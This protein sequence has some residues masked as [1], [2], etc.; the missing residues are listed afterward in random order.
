[1]SGLG[2]T[3]DGLFGNALAEIAHDTFATSAPSAEHE[4]L[5]VATIRRE[6]ADLI[7]DDIFTAPTADRV[8]H[9]AENQALNGWRLLVAEEGGAA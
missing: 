9:A 2:D 8:R 5:A 4:H 6:V 7:G 3:V 1:M